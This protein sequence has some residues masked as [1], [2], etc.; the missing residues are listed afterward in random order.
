VSEDPD[1][2]G[3]R[4]SSFSPCFVLPDGMSPSADY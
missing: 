1:R 2:A 3:V 4:I